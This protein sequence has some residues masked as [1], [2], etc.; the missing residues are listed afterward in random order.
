MSAS[1]GHCSKL[2]PQVLCACCPGTFLRAGCSRGARGE[3]ITV[4]QRWKPLTKDQM[5]FDEDCLLLNITQERNGLLLHF[6]LVFYSLFWSV[7]FSPQVHCHQLS[8]WILT[9]LTSSPVCL[10]MFPRVDFEE[11]DGQELTKGWTE[12]C[13]SYD[14]Q[15][16]AG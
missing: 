2:A 5:R 8:S 11:A 1:D 4:L 6:S 3:R 12:M 13:S 15:W 14:K 10:E 16:R 7:F 9:L